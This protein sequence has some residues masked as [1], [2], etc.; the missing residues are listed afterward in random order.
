MTDKDIAPLVEELRQQID[1]EVRFDELSRI[2]YSTDASMYQIMPIG[3]VVPRHRGD[4]LA[5]V[6]ACARHRVPIL[7]RCA[8]TSLAGQTVGRAVVM[9]MSKYM[10]AILEVN[11]QERWARVQPGVVLDELNAHLRPFGLMFAPDVATSNRAT[12]GGMVGNNSSGARSLIYGKTID[13]VLSLGVIL[14]DGTETTFGP[15]SDQEY[16]RKARGEGLEARIYREVKRIA[17][18]HRGEI[19][20]RFPKVQRRVGGYNLDEIV[21]EQP[22]N[23]AKF[24]TGSEGTLVTV[25]E[26]QVNLVPTPKM[27]ALDV[28]H[29]RSIPDAMEATTTVLETGP[30]A[31]ELTD[32]MILDLTKGNAEYARARTFLRGDP[33]AILVVEY[34]GQSQEELAGKIEDLE[35]RL[36]AKGMGYE[37]VRCLTPAEQGDV[38]KVRKAGVG[39]LMGTKGDGKPVAFVEDCCVPPERLP[40]Y[41]RRFDEIVR[42]HGTT[43]AYYAHASVGVLHVRPVINTKSL[44]D[45]RKMRSIAVQVRDMVLEYGGAM[46]GEHGD[47]LARSC[48]NEAMFGSELYEAFREV[49]RVFDPYGIMNPGKIVDAQ[50]MTENLRYGPAYRSEDLPTFFDFS[51]DGGFHRAVEMCNGNGVCRKKIEGGMCPSFMATREE[52][53]STRGRANALRAAIAGQMPLTDPRLYEAL[54]LCLECK[55]CKSECPSNV[56]MAKIKYEFLARYYERHGTP[57]RARLFGDIARLSRIGSALAPLSNRVIGS[58]PH[59]WLLDRL[60]GVDRRRHLMPF[61]RQTFMRWVGEQTADSRKGDGRPTTDDSRKGD[62]GR[63]SS[64]GGRREVVLFVDTFMNY[65]T[66]GVGIAAYTLLRRAGFEVVAPDRPCCGRPMISKGMIREAIH[67]ARRNVEVLYPYAARGAFIV[68]CEPSCVSALR[69]DYVDLLRSEEARTVAR[70]SVTVEEF[71]QDRH[72]AGGLNIRFSD[73]RR[74]VLL[75]GHCHQKALAGTGAALEVLRLPQGFEVS[76]IDSGCC[77]MA[78]SFGYEKEHYDVSIAIGE[79]RLFRAV[80]GAPDA[81]IAA[82]GISCRQQVLHGTGRQARHP[83][84][85][86]MDVI[87]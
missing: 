72:R 40:S 46:S 80:R 18:A 55:A 83:V 57:L 45:I 53:H 67:N 81:E 76:E 10:N 54:D 14:S 84:E 23:L 28:V 9:D 27:K 82:A 1:G 2:L 22:F 4:V 20:R 69:D 58:R 5:T 38:W 35:A 68:G 36:R 62:D 59:R 60:I 61:V 42:S 75:H 63:R 26:V 86:L 47:G 30:S 24:V 32:K 34:Y 85:I 78:G 11:A 50:D 19:E 17:E 65:N 12:V 3:V 52:E 64:V 48:W 87:L 73:A 15:V 43:A 66:P 16:E 21:R 51:A 70:Q 25:V 39:L 41:V 13:H 37:C 49:K 74:R 79:D 7:P 33:E 29:F 8:G 71:L 31:V 44:D 56:D 6:R 77:G